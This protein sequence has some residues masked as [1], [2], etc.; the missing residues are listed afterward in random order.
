[1]PEETSKQGPPTYFANFASAILN[2]D[3]MT[4]EFRR[5]G[6]P[7]RELFKTSGP[8]VMPI[9]PPSAQDIYQV[10]PVARVVLTF[11][12]AKPLKQYLDTALPQIEKQRKTQ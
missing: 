2:A 4:I 3:E 7:H 5:Y 6:P 1:M 9:P 10:E 8:E 12:A 11:T